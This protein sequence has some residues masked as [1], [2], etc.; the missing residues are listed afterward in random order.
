M[1]KRLLLQRKRRDDGMALKKISM[2]MC[3]DH[4]LAW[5]K[6]KSRERRKRSGLLVIQ[7]LRL[8]K[9]NKS[10]KRLRLRERK[11]R[12]RDMLRMARRVKLPKSD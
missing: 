5:R 3:E 2:K 1:L 8:R 11:R 4:K 7:P 12:R 9:A 10:R 6:R